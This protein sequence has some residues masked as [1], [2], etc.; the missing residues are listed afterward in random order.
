MDL[1]RDDDRHRHSGEYP[2][3]KPIDHKHS[4]KQS[5]RQD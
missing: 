5:P 3:S 2:D 4:F 1:G